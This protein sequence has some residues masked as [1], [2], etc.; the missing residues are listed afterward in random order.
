MMYTIEVAGFRW[1]DSAEVECC[2][3]DILLI[4]RHIA[5]DTNIKSMKVTDDNGL[6]VYFFD[7][8]K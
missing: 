3:Q 5:Q 4:T 7:D 8:F 2:Q 6:V 1:S